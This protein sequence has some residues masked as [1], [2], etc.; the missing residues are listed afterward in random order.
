MLTQR[1]DSIRVIV[2]DDG[3]GF[4]AGDV[5]EDALGVIGM[6]E[7]VA[8]VGGTLE[9]ESAPGAGTTLAAYVP[10][11]PTARDAPSTKRAIS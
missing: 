7:R 11:V 4:E 8:L 9:V 5:R 2:E 3:G 6:R 10:L 1:G